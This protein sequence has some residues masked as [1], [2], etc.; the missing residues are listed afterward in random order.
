MRLVGVL[1]QLQ[2]PEVRLGAPEQG[3]ILAVV[4]EKF[5]GFFGEFAHLRKSIRGIVRVVVQAVQD[6]ERAL[7]AAV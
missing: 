7:A 3:F 2:R 5:V 1:E 4:V 6:P